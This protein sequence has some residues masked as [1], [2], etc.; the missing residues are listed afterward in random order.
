MEHINVTVKSKHRVGRIIGWVIGGIAIAIVVAILLGWLIQ[1]LWAKT[2]VPLFDFPEISYW[3]AVGLVILARL[4]FGSI[5]GNDHDH[6]HHKKEKDWE[7]KFE[8]KCKSYFCR[9]TP[10][11]SP[12]HKEFSSYWK[13]EGESAFKAFLDGKNGSSGEDKTKKQTAEENTKDNSAE[14]EQTGE[15]I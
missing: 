14:E 6:H 5:G 3:Q 15:S 8:E 11:F 1:W 9:E 2:L 12:G 13:E 10:E 4:L 7:R